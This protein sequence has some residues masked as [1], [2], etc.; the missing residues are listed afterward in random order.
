V[1]AAGFSTS[2]GADGTAEGEL[3]GAADASG[4][5]SGGFLQAPSATAKPEVMSAMVSLLGVR[6]GL[7]EGTF[8]G[9]AAARPILAQTASDPARMR[10]FVP[11]A[12]RR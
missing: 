12:G 9:R 2:F 1:A 11:W 6:M 4:A 3:L 8:A 7:A 5:G 10:R